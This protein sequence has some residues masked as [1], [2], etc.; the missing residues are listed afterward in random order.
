MNAAGQ[1]VRRV[2][3]RAE[4]PIEARPLIDRLAEARLLIKD[5]RAVVGEEVEVIEVAHEAL[6]REWKD[7]NAALLE[8]REFLI[9]KGQLEQ[10]VA[11]WQATPEERMAGA[12]LTGNKLVRA[13]HWLLERPQDLTPDERQF[14]QVS[15][16][17]DERQQRQ[18][19]RLQ[20]S[21]TYGSVIAALVFA[22][23]GFYSW[24]A[25]QRA[26]VSEQ[27]A[28]AETQRA[29]E[30][31]QL[32]KAQTQRAEEKEQLANKNS[33]ELAEALVRVK[34]AEPAVEFQHKAQLEDSLQLAKQAEQDLRNGFVKA[35]IDKA[36]KALP[37]EERQIKRP[38]TPE[39]EL[40]L[41][42]ALQSVPR[43]LLTLKHDGAGSVEVQISSDGTH[44]LSVGERGKVRIWDLESGKPIRDFEG[45]HAALSPDGKLIAVAN[46]TR[47]DIF[48]LNGGSRIAGYDAANLIQFVNDIQFVTFS[49]DGTKIGLAYATDFADLL[50][51]KSGAPIVKLQQ[52]P[53]YSIHKLNFSPD[54]SR[55]LAIGNSSLHCASV[56]R[57]VR[58]GAYAPSRP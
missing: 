55:V 58:Q 39:A 56:R 25:E 15:A 9:A 30:K 5:R 19:A 20:R 4:I 31:E 22:G 14:I 23:L 11:E 8:E 6:L 50:D 13:R 43:P 21:L 47:L 3:T 12:L 10:D 29:E 53:T 18:R 33:A 46:G 37:D 41:Y 16:D 28:K 52:P 17:A 36:L 26:R 57:K 54:G 45:Q 34:A 38:Y 44:G 35:A 7:L 40:A 51:A 1:F 2:A 42:S 27:Q 48:D 24:R 32:A 49:R